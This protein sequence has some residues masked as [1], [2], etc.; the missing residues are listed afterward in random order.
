[1]IPSNHTNNNNNKNGPNSNITINNNS[2][3]EEIPGYSSYAGLGGYISA[4]KA[5]ENVTINK[6]RSYPGY[7]IIKELGT[8]Y[9]GNVYEA[10]RDKDNKHIAL[11]VVRIDPNNKNSLD[12]LKREVSIL[13]KIS[14][15]E[16]QP[17]LVCFH[18]YKYLEN[19]SIFLIEMDMVKGTTLDQFSKIY[20]NNPKFIRY[21]LLIMR[22]L[23]KAI[24]YLH[25]NDIIHN[26][27][28]PDNIII[29]SNLN[30]VL[31]DMGVACID[32]D[33][34]SLNAQEKKCCLNVKGPTIYLPPETILSKGA[35][36]K[37][38]DIWGLGLTYY[39]V[40]TEEFP[41]NIGPV[42]TPQRLVNSIKNQ[43]PMKLQS[44]NEIL[45]YIVNR[46]LDKN[47]STRITLSEIADILKDI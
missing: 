14:D 11:K 18:G 4:E 3:R 29:D 12:N 1:M 26:D 25:Q 32:V 24:Q 8:G 23:I 42:P 38:S 33:L 45:D 5:K 9:F 46:S 36:F 44:G 37:E 10:I 41:F 39:I 16:C 17:Y 2:S 20:K 15:P 21:L 6:N 13:S 34:C 47:L 19:D 35:Y 22:D 43:E 31:V 40:T 28:K 7:K 27:I 30:P